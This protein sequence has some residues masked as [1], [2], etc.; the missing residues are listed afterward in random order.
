MYKK[1]KGQTQAR[2]LASPPFESLGF[3]EAEAISSNLPLILIITQHERKN[4]MSHIPLK[5]T[6]ER[7]VKQHQAARPNATLG[8][9]LPRLDACLKKWATTK[10]INDAGKTLVL[11][12]ALVGRFKSPLAELI[13]RRII[14][15]FAGHEPEL[16]AAVD[17]AAWGI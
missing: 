17:K 8:R 5:W 3:A 12:F 15:A 10:D 14:A 7:I 9:E 2:P 13:G 6:P 16:A 11:C 1:N 4:K